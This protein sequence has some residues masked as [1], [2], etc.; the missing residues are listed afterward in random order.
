M[1]KKNY[2][3]RG[4]EPKHYV[5]PEVVEAEVAMESPVAEKKSKKSAKSAADAASETVADAPA[6]VSEVEILDAKDEAGAA[7]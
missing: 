3:N 7:E 1:R 6:E 5:E 4:A 2:R